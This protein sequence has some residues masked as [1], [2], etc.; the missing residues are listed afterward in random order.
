MPALRACI[1]LVTSYD[2]ADN[3]DFIADFTLFILW[4]EIEANVA[5]LVCCMPTLAP[6]IAKGYAGLT[7]HLSSPL[8]RRWTLISRGRTSGTEKDVHTPARTDT[9]TVELCDVTDTWPPMPTAAYHK[10]PR[11]SPALGSLGAVTAMGY[12]DL[13][14]Q[15]NQNGGILARTE[16]HRTSEP[17]D[18]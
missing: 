2:K 6:V 10:G 3:P 14:G 16:I 5:I 4:S 12:T 9:D 8:L 13:E 18:P 15:F 17:R 1:Y 7:Y 11:G